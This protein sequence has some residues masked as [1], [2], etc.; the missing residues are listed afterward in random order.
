ML[1]LKIYIPK[2]FAF[3]RLAKS[4]IAAAIQVDHGTEL[5]DAHAFALLEFFEFL[6]P[7]QLTPLMGPGLAA[8]LSATIES[9]FSWASLGEQTPLHTLLR[10]HASM[11][12]GLF[13]CAGE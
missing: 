10:T 6:A 5:N 3:Q 13:C 9:E 2:A 4:A 12:A 11:F 8:E 1:D 7:E